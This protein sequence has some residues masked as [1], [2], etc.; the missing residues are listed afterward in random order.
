MRREEAGYLLALAPS[1]LQVGSLTWAGARASSKGTQLLRDGA[2]SRFVVGRDHVQAQ[3][4]DGEWPEQTTLT[5]HNGSWRASC[6]CSLA[7]CAHAVAVLLFAQRE[8]RD[9]Q[10]SGQ[11]R[12]DVLSALRQRVQQPAAAV[13]QSTR[14]LSDIE[15]LPLPAAVDMVALGWRQ[16]QRPTATDAKPLAELAVRL[17]EL[18]KTEPVQARE[19]ALRLWSALSARKVVFTPLP[20]EAEEAALSLVPVVAGMGQGDAPDTEQL[21]FLTDLALAGGHVLPA[22]AATVLEM[23]LVRQPELLAKTLDLVTDWLLAHKPEWKEIAQPG[24]RDRLVSL[25]CSQCL[26]SGDLHGAAQLAMRWPPLRSVLL[27]LVEALADAGRLDDAQ[28]LADHFSPRDE[29]WQAVQLAAMD[30]AVRGG[31]AGAAARICAQ[32]L[33][34]VPGPVWLDALARVVPASEWQQVR[35]KQVEALVARD[36]QDAT[37]SAPARDAVTIDTTTVTQAEQV[38]RIVALA[39]AARERLRR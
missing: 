25:L 23:V 30:G 5:V 8:A 15:R 12:D 1:L 34:V 14:I 37:Q 2:V 27:T 13:P 26:A 11:Q 38:E 20:T 18:A 17:K 4:R 10:R 19:L 3:V 35:S 33:D 29:T 22:L 24:G 6:S 9:V 16:N 39:R 32:A 28:R 7:P 36:A 31:H 21:A